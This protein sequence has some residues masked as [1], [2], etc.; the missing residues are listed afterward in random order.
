MNFKTVSLCISRRLLNGRLD[1]PLEEE[2]DD[3]PDFIPQTKN[4]NQQCLRQNLILS[5]KKDRVFKEGSRANNKVGNLEL[6]QRERLVG[7]L[8]F[9]SFT[10]P[11]ERLHSRHLQRAARN[12]PQHQKNHKYLIP[13]KALQEC[14]WWLGNLQKYRQIFASPE[15]IFVTTDASDTG[16]GAQV[17][18]RILSGLW[19]INR[20]L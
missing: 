8:A 11:V 20:T 7:K 18:K 3:E 5:H 6:G 16:W 2:E 19:K 14:F 15:T 10:V 4:K 9:A 13:T 1:L 17:N 12:L